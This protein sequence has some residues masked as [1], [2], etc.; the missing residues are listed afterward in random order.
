[1]ETTQRQR[2]S[3]LNN[4][5]FAVSGTPNSGYLG[6]RGLQRAWLEKGKKRAR[7]SAAILY[8]SLICATRQDDVVVDFLSCLNK[9]F[10][11]LLGPG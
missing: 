10:S 5:S 1:M 6:L 4:E 8:F 3:N 9:R 11:R 7:L 2:L